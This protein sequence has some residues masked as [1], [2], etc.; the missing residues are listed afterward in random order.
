MQYYIYLN[1]SKMQG[2]WSVVTL[3]AFSTKYSVFVCKFQQNE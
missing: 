3:S 2:N 1:A